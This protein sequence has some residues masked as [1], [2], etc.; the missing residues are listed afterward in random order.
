[1]PDAR[2]ESTRFRRSE[3]VNKCRPQA[4]VWVNVEGARCSAEL[5]GFLCADSEAMTL[6]QWQR[7]VHL[8]A[9]MGTEG[10]QDPIRW[11]GGAPAAR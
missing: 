7:D 9:L 4:R 3:N 10:G 5:R 2:P 6:P 1:M 8:S 11:I